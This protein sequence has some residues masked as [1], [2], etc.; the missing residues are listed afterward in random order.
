[1]KA[2]T[3]AGCDRPKQPGRG[4]KLCAE[5][6]ATA[7][8][9][10]K[11]KEPCSIDGCDRP[12]EARSWCHT[13]YEHYRTYG[14]PHPRSLSDRFEAKV[15]RE[16]P[17][18]DSGGRCWNWT[19]T[20]TKHGYGQVSVDGVH[21][22]AHRVSY[23]LHRGPIPDGLTIDHLCRNRRCVN[24]AHLEPVTQAENT[25]RAA[26]AVEICPAGHA[27]DAVNTYVHPTSGYRQC[28]ACD[29]ERHR[30]SAA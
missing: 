14:S 6:K 30:R 20:G 19:G 2:C 11:P 25:R 22:Y 9:R 1:M 10:V 7:H 24:P 3:V 8:L 28:R 23:E 27:Y 12:V 26:D 4:K 13:H 17:P 29:R 21:R 18:S 15:D 5:C 16:G